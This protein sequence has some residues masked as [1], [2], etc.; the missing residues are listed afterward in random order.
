MK[1]ISKLF[2]VGMLMTPNLMAYSNFC[3]VN[4]GLCSSSPR[5]VIVNPRPSVPN[6]IVRN[7]AV[8]VWGAPGYWDCVN[9]WPYRGYHHHH[10]HHR[11]HHHRGR[12]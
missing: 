7:G 1:I 2:V 4:P 5:V 3:E 9:G 11:H 8:C 10:G 12:H 6:V